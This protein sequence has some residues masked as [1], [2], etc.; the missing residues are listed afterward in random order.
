[1]TEATPHL[2]R[3]YEALSAQRADFRN[4]NLIELISRAVEG[5]DVVDLGAGSGALAAHLAALG[6]RV[7]AVE[8]HEELVRLAKSLHPGLEVRRGDAESIDQMLPYPVDA[9]VMID[10][11]E[12]IEDD[13]AVL[14]KLRTMLRPEGELV[15]LVP[16]YPILYG[17]RDRLHGH[18]RRYRKRELV[19]MLALSGYEVRRARYW[20]MLAVPFYFISEKLFRRELSSALRQEHH[21]PLKRLVNRMLHLWFQHLENRLN[22]G[23]GLS[24][25][26]VARRLPVR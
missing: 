1:M 25:L 5:T 7:L 11:L 3:H 8:P 21:H 2:V 26:V 10:V 23:F 4:A 12:H 14:K 17:V 22:L 20:N 16:A 9:F 15:I 18:F 19:R 6:K 24:L 13:A